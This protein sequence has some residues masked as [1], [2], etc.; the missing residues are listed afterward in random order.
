MRLILPDMKVIFTQGG[1]PVASGAL[2][3]KIDLDVAPSNNGY[4]VAIQLGKPDLSIDV[5]DDIPNETRFADKD[6]S[7]AVELAL[8]SQIASISALLGA[9]PL[10][11]VAGLQMKN[12]SVGGDS[13]YVMVKGD[14]Q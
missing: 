2:N 10:P 14:L 6:L 8:G 3:A 13:G 1:S 4:T 7:T 12:L 5:T 11:Q 9:V